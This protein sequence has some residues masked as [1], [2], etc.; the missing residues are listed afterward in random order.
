MTGL[1]KFVAVTC[2]TDRAGYPIFRNLGQLC[3]S[4]TGGIYFVTVNQ[5]FTKDLWPG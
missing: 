3:T 2:P 1:G 5:S 4:L